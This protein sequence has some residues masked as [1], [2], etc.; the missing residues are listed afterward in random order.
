[1]SFKSKGKPESTRQTGKKRTLLKRGDSG[2]GRPEV[3]FSKLHN[4]VK[5]KKC[6]SDGKREG[7]RYGRGDAL[8]IV[9][10]VL[11]KKET[12]SKPDVKKREG[13]LKPRMKR[14][15]PFTGKKLT[16]RGTRPVP[17]G[18]GKTRTNK[19]KIIPISR[20]GRPSPPCLRRKNKPRAGR[21]RNFNIKN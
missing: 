1:M 21:R 15:S 12:I 9:S 10:R 16:G 8:K 11:E 13:S 17:K 14:E 4:V 6:A 18:K 5:E 3:R 20:D 7:S 19:E 2:S